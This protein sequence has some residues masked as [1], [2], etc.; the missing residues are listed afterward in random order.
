MHASSDAAYDWIESLVNNPPDGFQH[1]DARRINGFP[2]LA[3][4]ASNSGS[5]LHPNSGT[6]A[7]RRHWEHSLNEIGRLK[8]ADMQTTSRRR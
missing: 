4:A 6:I 2:Q 7:G 5:G 3:C 8:S 1:K